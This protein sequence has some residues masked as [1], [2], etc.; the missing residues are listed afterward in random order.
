MQLGGKLSRL[1]RVL[2]QSHLDQPSNPKAASLRI[3]LRT[4]NAID[5]KPGRRLKRTE[6]LPHMIN[7]YCADP[8]K[9]STFAIVFQFFLLSFLISACRT[10]GGNH[11]VPHA[12]LVPMESTAVSYRR[13]VSLY[14]ELKWICRSC[15]LNWGALLE[16]RLCYL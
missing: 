9:D 5:D 10:V 11:Q 13:R 6:L 3:L 12:Q 15:L 16:G 1:V 4:E 2:V 14:F 7:T 8:P